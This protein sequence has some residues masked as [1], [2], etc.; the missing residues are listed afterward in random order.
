MDSYTYAMKAIGEIKQIVSAVNVGDLDLATKRIL[1]AKTVFVA[2]AGRSLLML[3][4][5]AM[6]LM[7][8]G[9]SVHVVGETTTPAITANDLLLIASGSGET[10]TMLVVAKRAVA[11]GSDLVAVTANNSSSLA[12]CARHLVI[13]PASSKVGGRYDS[14]QPSGN[15][16]EQSLLLVL[17]GIALHVARTGGYNFAETLN[18]HANLE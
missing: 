15:S 9:L 14:W 8:F 17:D 2:G 12:A 6:R 5:F 7:H 16:F 10:E 4:A 18:R 11:L 13:I 1:A 3:K